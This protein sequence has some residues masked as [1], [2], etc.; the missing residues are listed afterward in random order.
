M[1]QARGKIKLWSMAATCC[2]KKQ[3]KPLKDSGQFW[4]W[5][6][7]KLVNS[8]L[9]LQWWGG[10]TWF[11]SETG[12]LKNMIWTQGRLRLFV[13]FGMLRSPLVP[14]V[15]YCFP[16]LRLVNC[17]CCTIRWVNS[18][19]TVAGKHPAKDSVNPHLHECE[20]FISSE[21]NGSVHELLSRWQHGHHKTLDTAKRKHVLHH[22]G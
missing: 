17:V 14:M 1:R 3:R 8:P 13:V 19:C 6:I 10:G 9:F 22:I 7:S 11:V 4:S 20:K 2:L 21:K 5:Y 16:C 18:A 12:H 15:D